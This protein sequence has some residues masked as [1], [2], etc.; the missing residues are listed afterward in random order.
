MNLLKIHRIFLYFAELS[1]RLRV[2]EPNLRFVQVAQKISQ[3]LV[4][5]YILTF[6]LK[7]GIIYLSRGQ[8]NRNRT[9][10]S[11]ENGNKKIENFS[12]KVLTKY[13]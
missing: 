5:N 13:Q 9:K 8:G 4:Q 10:A 11:T 1:A 2:N 3:N 7:Y 12:K 6:S